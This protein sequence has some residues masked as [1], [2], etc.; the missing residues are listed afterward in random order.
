MGKPR[1]H[2]HTPQTATLTGRRTV[3]WVGV[4]VA[5]LLLSIGGGLQLRGL[6]ESLPGPGF[7]RIDWDAVQ[8]GRRALA[9]KAAEGNILNI[10]SRYV[11]ATR[12]HPEQVGEW[13]TDA[14]A[15]VGRLHQTQ[16]GRLHL[17]ALTIRELEED[18]A[19]VEAWWARVRAYIEGVDGAACEHFLPELLTAE[20]N[21]YARCGFEAGTA[22]ALAQLNQGHIHGPFLQY[23]VDRM[24]RLTAGCRAS[25]DAEAAA[26]CDR[27]VRSLLKQWVIQPGPAGLRLLAAELLA[28]KI[29]GAGSDAEDSGDAQLAVHLRACRASYRGRALAAAELPALLQAGD[30]PLPQI[31]TWL[32]QLLGL[33]AWSAGA[34]VAVAVCALAFGGLAIRGRGRSGDEAANKKTLGAAFVM[35]PLVSL[36]AA[37]VIVLVGWLVLLVAPHV[38]EADFQRVV[39]DDLGWPVLPIAGGGV[40]VVVL[41]AAGVA[42]RVRRGTGRLWNGQQAALLWLLLSVASIGLVAASR[43]AFND[44]ERQMAAALSDDA[45]DALCDDA[46]RLLAELRVWEP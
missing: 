32:P 13:L 11:L 21:S 46:Q 4:V 24:A 15:G 14:R 20:A 16:L 10:L 28:E 31:H 17:A 43:A 1:Q 39:A 22:R 29:E 44:Y 41:L 3:P 2:K 8:Q 25:G 35:G 19:P 5:A 36:V 34:L 18:D 37:A 38:L 9:G 7:G 33:T 40:G 12:K 6:W 27:L 30:E 26:K 23:F 45:P 42:E